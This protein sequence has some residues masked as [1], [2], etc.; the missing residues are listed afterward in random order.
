MAGSYWEDSGQFYEQWEPAEQQMW[1]D[2]TNGTPAHDDL[3]AQLEFDVG[4][5]ER[6]LWTDD[7]IDLQE[8]HEML[9]EYLEQ[10]GIDF[11]QDFDWIAYREWYES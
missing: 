1:D 6:D 3:T 7:D 2:L 9:A 8:I 11:D 4:Y 5:F 10:F